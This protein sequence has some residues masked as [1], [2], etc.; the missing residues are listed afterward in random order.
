MAGKG[1]ASFGNSSLA[2]SN[3]LLNQ[4]ITMGGPQRNSNAP[5][6][7]EKAPGEPSSLYNKSTIAHDVLKA[8]GASGFKNFEGTVP[9]PTPLNQHAKRIT[10]LVRL[11]YSRIPGD[12]STIDWERVERDSKVVSKGPAS[13]REL[14][15][16]PDF[17][18][19]FPPPLST[20]DAPSTPIEKPS[21]PKATSKSTPKSTPK[22]VIP[23]ADDA[24]RSPSQKRTASDVSE[25]S[26]PTP[27]RARMVAVVINNRSD[28]EDKTPKKQGSVA[29]K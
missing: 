11:G 20:S 10:R 24:R 26:R 19:P 7:A 28:S 12:L 4:N 16:P 13:Q 14:P 2:S 9:L 17:P 29:P 15:K 25:T 23:L 5:S 21:T 27:K 3:S 18:A 6:V 8:S 22:V 1:Q